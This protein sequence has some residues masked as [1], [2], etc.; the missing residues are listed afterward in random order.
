LIDA[1]VVPI[2]LDLLATKM[3]LNVLARAYE[4]FTYPGS[5]LVLK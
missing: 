5:G 2:P 1:T 4:L 3:G